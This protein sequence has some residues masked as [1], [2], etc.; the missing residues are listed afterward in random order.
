MKSSNIRLLLIAL[1]LALF[2]LAPSRVSAHEP[3]DCPDGFPDS[4]VLWGHIQQDQIVNGELTFDQVFNAG[5]VLFEVA[6][7]LCDGQGR[8]GT[9]GTGERRVPD[10]PAFIRSSAPESNSCT[11]C[12]NQPRPGGG[13]DFVANV[14]VLAQALDPVTDSLSPEFSNERNTL[15]MFGAGPIEM[16]SR[17]MTAD[18]QS[19]RE[20]AVQEA[21][22]RGEPVTKPLD[23][24]GVSF[25]EISAFPDGSVDVSQVLGIDADLII[26]PF[27]Q[28]GVV[29]SIREFT[30]N[31]M[32]HHLG[33]QAEER[34]DLYPDKGVDFDK[35]GV[36]GELTIGDLTA[37][38][39]FQAALG[40]PGRVLPAAQAER[41][42][43]E[44]GENLFD[45]LGCTSCHLPEMRLES[46]LFEEPNPLNPPGTFNDTSLSFSFDMTKVGE[47]P[48]PEKAAG[49]GAIL[50]PYTDLKRHNLCDDLDHPAP[51]RFYC[52]E[53]LAQG[54]PDQKGRQGTQ[55]FLTRKLWDVGNSAPYGHRGDLTTITEAI[56]AHGGEARMQRDSFVALSTEDQGAIVKFLK[57]L[58]VLPAGSP[59]VITEPHRVIIPP[60]ESGLSILALGLLAVVMFS[61]FK[62]F[63]WLRRNSESSD[64]QDVNIH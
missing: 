57:T 5:Q 54:R 50:R 60:L 23:T 56:L 62:P 17:E 55:F 33:M 53:Q 24:K 11:G 46:R 43:V 13:G 41:E 51:I 45:Q 21:I 12:H 58:Q 29:L 47:K 22:E 36:S 4:P 61:F 39:T 34:F 8:P 35:D 64:D 16:L 32:N 42:T 28:A 7:N 63:G 52:N 20:A 6:F 26:K 3:H 44:L 27:H 31:A 15:G 49:G 38:T 9:T 2:L 40:I 14:F 1:I 59:R 25:G 30:A 37:I 48:R 19:I 18:L 10:E